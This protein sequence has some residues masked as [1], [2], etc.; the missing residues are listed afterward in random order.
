MLAGTDF[1]LR[2]AGVFEPQTSVSLR[3]QV[4]VRSGLDSGSGFV[5]LVR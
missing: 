4:A 2:K 1:C 3:A 5:V